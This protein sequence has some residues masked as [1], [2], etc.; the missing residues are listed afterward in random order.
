MQLG[1]RMDEIGDR[2]T[3][4]AQHFAQRRMLQQNDILALDSDLGIQRQA[5]ANEVLHLLLHFRAGQGLALK[6]LGL[7]IVGIVENDQEHPLLVVG[8]VHC[9]Q[10]VGFPRDLDGLRLFPHYKG[11][12]DNRDKQDD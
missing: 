2:Q 11:A 10:V 7:R 9:V 12:K 4:P 6:S 3:W 5:D 1:V 8:N